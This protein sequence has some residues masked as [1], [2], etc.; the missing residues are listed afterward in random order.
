M[1]LL[2]YLGQCCNG[3]NCIALYQPLGVSDVW[4]LLSKSVIPALQTAHGL[5][6]AGHVVK[7][8]LSEA[9]LYRKKLEGGLSRWCNKTKTP[10]GGMGSCVYDPVCWVSIQLPKNI[11]QTHAVIIFPMQDTEMW[12]LSSQGNLGWALYLLGIVCSCL[13]VGCCLHMKEA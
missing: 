10:A 3:L 12:L 8:M 7:K 13:Q 5:I 4:K 11:A 6:L 2:S 9:D 1:Y